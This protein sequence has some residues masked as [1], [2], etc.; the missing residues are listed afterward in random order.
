MFIGA[1]QARKWGRRSGGDRRFF[2]YAIYLPEKRRGE[3][4]KYDRRTASLIPD[5]HGALLK[6]DPASPAKPHPHPG[7]SL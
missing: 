2:G 7:Q 1:T 6:S 3:R 4:R 5:T